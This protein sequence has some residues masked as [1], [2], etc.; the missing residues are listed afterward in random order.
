MNII[1]NTTNL[2]QGGVLQVTLSF[3]D[4]I[5]RIQYHN[6]YVFMTPK[7]SDQLNTK[8]FPK[9]FKFYEIK[10]SPKSIPYGINIIR[11]LKKLERNIDPDCV[12]STFG[13]TYWT[14]N[15]VH[16]MGFALPHYIYPE[17]FRKIEFSLFERYLFLI[18]KIFHKYFI[19][20]NANYYITETN[21]ASKRLS[22]FIN[23]NENKIFTVGN[24]F[25]S[26]Y[27]NPIIDLKMLPPK[28]DK[29]Y[30]F[31]TIS[32][33]YKHKNLEIINKII[34]FIRA[35]DINIKFILTLPENIFLKKFSHC[36][37]YI[38][39]VGP[40][41]VNNCPY[42]YSET[43]AL[44]LPTLLE[45][46]SAS[47]PEAMKMGKPILTSDLSF[48]HDI[49]GEAAEYFN[50]TDP[51]DIA[52]KIIGLVKN[53]ERQKELVLKGKERLKEFES[54]ESRAKRY[55]E[56]CKVIAEKK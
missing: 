53:I 25:S 3:L 38:I 43:D 37:K 44:F 28:S 2:Q 1:I 52:S 32:A 41:P 50:P 26:I 4:E 20:K 31:I 23:V 29:E 34:P 22:K 5:K 16:L 39:N 56:I 33:F 35:L 13:P 24:T 14:P 21:D 10:H 46:F 17:Y 47:Y 27:N 40:I 55:L 48:A 45:C 42:L 9:N 18:K 15:A 11:H 6:F 51:E 36:R 19:R 30:R 49:C 7:I 12:F 54:S 8:T